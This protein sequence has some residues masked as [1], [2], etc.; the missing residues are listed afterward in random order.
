MIMQQLHARQRRKGMVNAAFAAGFGLLALVF[1]FP[2]II[3]LSTAL[4]SDPDFLTRGVFSFPHSLR[5]ANFSDAWQTGDFGTTYKNSA[6]ITVVKVPLGLLVSALAAYPLAKMRFRLSGVFFIY[7]VAGLAVP[8]HVALLPLFVIDRN[9]GLLG[10]LWALLGPYLAFGIPFQVFVLRGFMRLIPGE[11]MEAARVDGAGELIVFVRV[12]L[13]LIV[14]ALA[15]LCILDV[16]ATWNE[17]LM[18]LVLLP[19]ADVHTLPLGLLNF[20]NQFSGSYTQLSA[21]IVLGVIPLLVVY[22]FLQRYLISGLLGGAI[23]A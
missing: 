7:F 17:F 5:L 3:L 18:A 23:K 6:L 22:M 19:N 4:R 20:F 11:L 1:M 10:S 12:V 21:G 15:T 16:V 14:P 2:M 9:L 13:P 8:V